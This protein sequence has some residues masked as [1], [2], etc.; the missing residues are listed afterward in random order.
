MKIY[1]PAAL[2]YFSACLRLDDTETVLYHSIL[3]TLSR[4]K[5]TEEEILFSL[6]NIVQCDTPFLIYSFP[7]ALKQL[8]KINKHDRDVA[9][10][11]GNY[12]ALFSGFFQPGFQ[13]IA[14]DLF[15]EIR[16][17]TKGNNLSGNLIALAESTYS[18]HLNSETFENNLPYI[19]IV[20]FGA[21]AVVLA[22]MA[23]FCHNQEVANKISDYLD[24]H[25]K[26][27]LSLLLDDSYNHERG[28]VC[29]LISINL[30]RDLQS[31]VSKDSFYK[32]IWRNNRVLPSP[33]LEADIVFSF[34][35]NWFV[36]LDRK[37]S[38]TE[39]MTNILNEL[40][41]LTLF[42]R[43]MVFF[44]LK[45]NKREDFLHKN[46]HEY[47]K[48]LFGKEPDT[49]S[50][51]HYKS[52]I[53]VNLWIGSIYLLLCE[54][55]ELEAAL[56]GLSQLWE[57][58][59]YNAPG[60]SFNTG[61]EF[62]DQKTAA[63][64]N[65]RAGGNPVNGSQIRGNLKIFSPWLV[66]FR[67]H[68]IPSKYLESDLFGSWLRM[69]YAVQVSKSISLRAAAGEKEK[70]AHY[71]VH[72]ADVLLYC[73]EIIAGNSI[74]DTNQQGTSIFRSIQRMPNLRKIILCLNRDVNDVVGKGM[75]PGITH[76][77][78]IS[79]L[80]P[81]GSS[82]NP[83]SYFLKNTL[84]RVVHSW[85][86]YS[87]QFRPFGEDKNKQ[88]EDYLL[89][90]KLVGSRNKIK[91]MIFRKYLF[92][93]PIQVT[94]RFD[95]ITD[96]VLLLSPLK[97]SEIR[98]FDDVKQDNAYTVRQDN[99]QLSLAIAAREYEFSLRNDLPESASC[100][101]SLV[102]LLKSVRENKDISYPNRLALI[103]LFN[104]FDLVTDQNKEVFLLIA[105]TMF[106]FNG[107]LD[108]SFLSGKILDP[109]LLMPHYSYNAAQVEILNILSS[110]ISGSLKYEIHERNTA[111]RPQDPQLN[112]LQNRKINFLR[113][114]LNIMQFIV[115]KYKDQL[116]NRVKVLNYYS[117]TTGGFKI[118]E[119]P[120]SIV[121]DIPVFTLPSG[122]AGTPLNEPALIAY[123]KIEQVAQFY[124]RN[125]K[126]PEETYRFFGLT[127]EEIRNIFTENSRQ[128]YVLAICTGSKKQG[129]Q[130][131]YW[132][133]YAIGQYQSILL[134]ESD[135]SKGDL[136][137]LK[138]FYS[139]NKQAWFI[140][141]KFCRR[142]AEAAGETDYIIIKNAKDFLTRPRLKLDYWLPCPAD[143][144]TGFLVDYLG[145]DGRMIALGKE[146]KPHYSYFNDLIESTWDISSLIVLTF[147]DIQWDEDRQEYGYLFYKT[148]GCHFLIFEDE[149]EFADQRTGTFL[150][151]IQEDLPDDDL[152]AI[153]LNGLLA[154]FH[155]ITTGLKVKLRV[156]PEN[157][158]PG[159]Y[160]TEEIERRYPLLQF[161]FDNR[162]IKWK[163]LFEDQEDKEF[164]AFFSE[165]KW[166]CRFDDDG[167]WKKR[168]FKQPV[169]VRLTGKPEKK[170][171]TDFLVVDGWGRDMGLFNFEIA[172][173]VIER[174]SISLSQLKKY[175]ALIPG[176]KVPV[177][178]ILLF[179]KKIAVQNCYAKEQFRV[180][181]CLEEISLAPIQLD[182]IDLKSIIPKL[183]LFVGYVGPWKEM[184]SEL[185]LEDFSPPAN[186]IDNNVIS[187]YF[188]SIPKS[189]EKGI[190]S[191]TIVLQRDENVFSD[192]LEIDIQN[193][194]DDEIK[195]NLSVYS[196]FDGILK[197]G[198]WH[199]YFSTRQIFLKTARELKPIEGPVTDEYMYIGQ[200]TIESKSL[201]LFEKTGYYG[202]LFYSE[203]DSEFVFD[204]PLYW[205]PGHISSRWTSRALGKS[206]RLGFFYNDSF[207][208]GE[209]TKKLF[210]KPA[211]TVFL[212]EISYKLDPIDTAHY[213]VKRNFTVRVDEIPLKNTAP[214]INQ[215]QDKENEK[216]LDLIKEYFLDPYELSGKLDKEQLCIELD[217]VS[218]L[219]W[220]YSNGEWGH[221]IPLQDTG[222][223][224]K[225]RLE[226]LVFVPSA[227]SNYNPDDVVFWL[228][229][230]GSGEEL[231]TFKYGQFSID[232]LF[233]RYQNEF[234]KDPGKI[235]DSK[236]FFCEAETKHPF[237]E[238]EFEQKMYRFEEGFGKNILI[239][240]ERVLWN[241][242]PI[243]T[244]ELEMLHGDT[245]KKIGFV[246]EIV[247][248]IEIIK[249][250]I[251]LIEHS[252]A[253]R[254]Y[255][256]ASRDNIYHLAHVGYHKTGEPYIKYVKGVD[257]RA[258]K[259][260]SMVYNYEKIHAGFDK[261]SG[262]LLR[263]RFAG[264]GKTERVVL[265]KVDI[266]VFK[267]TQRLQFNHHKLSFN[268][269]HEGDSIK[270]LKGGKDSVARVIMCLGS[271]EPTFNGNDYFIG[272]TPPALLDEVDIGPEFKTGVM[273]RRAFSKSE[274]LLRE[275]Y[276][277]GERDNFEDFEAFITVQPNTNN[278]NRVFFSLVNNYIL[279]NNEI[280]K[281]L[282]RDKHLVAIAKKDSSRSLPLVLEIKPGRFFQLEN[283]ILSFVGI[284]TV[285]EGDVLDISFNDNHFQIESAVAA[286]YRFM[287]K[288]RKV[289][290]LAKDSAFNI[291]PENQHN[292][293]FPF[294]IGELPNTGI[295]FYDADIDK[296][297]MFLTKDHPRLASVIK[298]M[299]R[300]EEHPFITFSMTDE[301]SF[302]GYI[303]FDEVNKEIRFITISGKK[304]SNHLINWGSSSLF[305]GSADEIIKRIKSCRW[306]YHDEK[307]RKFI[308]NGDGLTLSEF[309]SLP[310]SSV[311]NAPKCIPGPV[312]CE[313]N[314]GTPN[315]R[316]N[317]N[318]F[319]WGYPVSTLLEF[320]DY[321]KVPYRFAYAGRQGNIHFIEI[322]PGRIVEL[323]TNLLFIRQNK[324][325]LPIKDY[326]W[327]FLSVGDE[328]ELKNITG[329]VS[330]QFKIELVSIKH[331][332]RN[333]LKQNSVLPINKIDH[334]IGLLELGYQ[335]CTVRLPIASLETSFDI[336]KPV[337]FISKNNF[338]ANQSIRP[339]LSDGVS[340][341]LS[342][343]EDDRFF[344]LGY[345]K[346]R[347]T[348]ADNEDADR[349]YQLIVANEGVIP[350]I[351]VTSGEEKLVQFK[352][353]S[354]LDVRWQVD[355]KLISAVI[356]NIL[357]ADFHEVV[358][359]IG[360]YFEIVRFDEIIPGVPLKQ[361]SFVM[362]QMLKRQI[363]V[364]VTFDSLSATYR[365]TSGLE[366]R[367]LL[368]E[369]FV[370]KVGHVVDDNNNFLGTLCRATSSL[371]YY[372]MPEEEMAWCDITMETADCVFWGVGNL[373]IKKSGGTIKV[374]LCTTGGTYISRIRTM[375]LINAFGKKRCGS[376]AIDV[377]AVTSSKNKNG[378]EYGFIGFSLLH[379]VLVRCVAFSGTAK[380][381]IDDSL[382]RTEVVEK[383]IKGL[384]LKT[385]YG[386]KKFLVHMP[387]YNK[388]SGPI[389]EELSTEFLK[390]INEYS[391]YSDTELIRNSSKIKSVYTEIFNPDSSERT[392][393]NSSLI[394]LKL[395][396][397]LQILQ[398]M[399]N[400]SFFI[401]ELIRLIRLNL[402]RHIS[403]ETIN[404]NEPYK[405]TGHY[406]EFLL[407]DALRPFYDS[408]TGEVFL[409]EL[410]IR[411][412]RKLALRLCFQK[413]DRTY[414]F[415]GNSILQVLGLKS[416]LDVAVIKDSAFY[417]IS[418]TLEEYLTDT[419]QPNIDVLSDELNTIIKLVEINRFHFYLQKEK[420][421]WM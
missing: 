22:L 175:L 351:I 392:P 408:K 60:I 195:L 68:R 140:D 170:N 19:D 137:Q 294:T 235:F 18:A 404:K 165:G 23:Y 421:N 301:I 129:D 379:K 84:P 268:Q 85:L 180:C 324:T 82:A 293:L 219:R 227:I 47:L 345:E 248:D 125:V 67:R 234:E 103:S 183:S 304:V 142:L 399:I 358:L 373:G 66:L 353:P 77:Y 80:N 118:E 169:T 398:P 1:N 119:N 17:V 42:C 272:I 338:I 5:N 65:A 325:E 215:N 243:R 53:A 323:P 144:F 40:K 113:H 388:P 207:I 370:M 153:S 365:F 173:E 273:F 102:H 334:R 314:F 261:A 33:D 420:L 204:S 190:G 277:R 213:F 123:N 56:S 367:L 336:D 171:E 188:I 380:P 152:D 203:S 86:Y 339:F 369:L 279:K 218:K 413:Q 15:N 282:S 138:Y 390:T 394:I 162:N 39:R 78:F 386:D 254:L 196:R 38:E 167:F 149:I 330:D 133:Q 333:V 312:F 238:E 161:P 151:F 44:N 296:R 409:S 332:F 126:L 284:Q 200:T 411:K 361:R 292:N 407:N 346:L 221:R 124:L 177:T 321:Y 81:Q 26:S 276:R 176:V 220:L 94:E 186:Y 285:K 356:V 89:L 280:I 217:S 134:P 13:E 7:F 187:G 50:S 250:N 95:N 368:D 412:L 198:K 344:V 106:E 236:I 372:W 216:R 96:K 242:K 393:L 115:T 247:N 132:F 117:A 35:E 363:W 2:L 141:N 387:F 406:V 308:K 295:N 228:Y 414:P 178:T 317:K 127:D 192:E 45:A 256:Q 202:T 328:I 403:I 309:E 249:L 70:F 32:H 10:L 297:A 136:I 184:D 341:L 72:A 158:A 75:L 128:F 146:D 208:S 61:F 21:E 83:G 135:L 231:A 252:Q 164:S 3:E 62:I 298:H 147:I 14:N 241:Y 157:T 245:V 209:T 329:N 201:Y 51:F 400:Y 342:L 52:S 340:A 311:T 375:E 237:T 303:E 255:L 335:N 230:S 226:E 120:V 4:E 305:D 355:G 76:R 163:N 114:I 223:S 313:N 205:K 354:L 74:K 222:K 362:Q 182:G 267:Q 316:Y 193:I 287:E 69:M 210:L 9:N 63:I 212:K 87:I 327:N 289:V 307:S 366:Q 25:Q 291:D 257:E 224:I 283:S 143:V 270:V 181:I 381:R 397:R 139:K 419:D 98:D 116:G 57:P 112:L 101:A 58:L 275:Y 29:F 244:A 264:D 49:I 131:R 274:G 410:S 225:D 271:I 199:Y 319:F 6:K 121:D 286:D 278:R 90:E 258:I 34:L 99:S 263:N 239:P 290:V 352:I 376:D 130:T 174:R 37:S 145:K 214:R 371:R 97:L 111:D 350:V 416:D 55:F 322:A 266:E 349:I 211:Q 150:E 41:D 415:I 229:K 159:E 88:R 189:K 360:G 28:R 302:A 20:E 343:T 11:L 382:L 281:T 265:V 179:S 396:C 48:L 233:E 54:H 43:C 357:N 378:H 401:K 364:R 185:I 418:K 79:L 160:L 108:I 46:Y 172:G 384:K 105:E 107:F 347:P 91:L 206:L 374:K 16:G 8:S 100:K 383:N 251:I 417:K 288:G 359:R 402:L 232:D 93:D 320:L 246:K 299:Y 73:K 155:L 24:E 156:V 389:L 337:S 377:V 326:A 30:K 110:C 12:M 315:L 71:I 36:L 197:D 27:P 59:S 260:D 122:Y 166:I 318:F 253:Y 148:L 331:G 391:G 348:I 405:L 31:I 92:G 104:E 395:F 109:L 240:E 262:E 194:A 191:C 64:I 306:R 154:S 300:A 310:P 168:G 259:D 269:N 385:L